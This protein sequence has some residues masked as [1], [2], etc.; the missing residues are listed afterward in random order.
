[1][2]PDT[3]LV[4]TRRRLSRKIFASLYSLKRQQYFL[5]P[6]LYSHAHFS[7][8]FWTTGTSPILITLRKLL[9]SW[10]GCK[11]SALHLYLARKS[12][13]I[14]PGLG[15]YSSSQKFSLYML[16][17]SN[18]SS[19]LFAQSLLSIFVSVFFTIRLWV[20][21]CVPAQICPSYTQLTKIVGFVHCKRCSYVEVNIREP[22]VAVWLD[23][24]FHK[25]PF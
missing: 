2:N 10:S 20:T 19:S 13:T 21:A 7:F 4:G 11:I 9:I 17:L 8:L 23:T 15:N 16:P 3:L 5:L 18:A 14:F 6:N 1:M 25:Y 24:H 22:K 12:M